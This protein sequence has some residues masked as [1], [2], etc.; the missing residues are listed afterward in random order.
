MLSVFIIEKE[1]PRT[2]N[3]CL[4]LHSHIPEYYEE[5]GWWKNGKDLATQT[6]AEPQKVHFKTETSLCVFL[7]P[8]DDDSC[9]V[10]SA[11]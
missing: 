1:W 10:G 5:T 9:E 6:I 8:R 3:M 11:S 2:M 7:W 4:W